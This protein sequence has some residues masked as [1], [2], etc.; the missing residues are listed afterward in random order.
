MKS[1]INNTLITESE[2]LRIPEWRYATK[3]FNPDLKLS[4]ETVNSLLEAIR[5]SPSSMGL[6]PYAFVRVANTD[7]RDALRAVSSDQPQI[8]D[9]SELIVFAAKTEISDADI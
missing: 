8:T 4:D 6:Q 2:L 7:L 3:K 1:T 5:L 9:A